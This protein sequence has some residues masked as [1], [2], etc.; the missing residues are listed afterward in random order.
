MSIYN[1]AQIPRTTTYRPPNDI[2]EQKHNPPPLQ[3]ELH[4][5]INNHR[6]IQNLLAKLDEEATTYRL[7]LLRTLAA[8]S[9]DA[10]D[11]SFLAVVARLKELGEERRRH[12]NHLQKIESI[13]QRCMLEFC[14]DFS[15]IMV[16]NDEKLEGHWFTLTKPT[17]TDCLG[18][19]DDGDPLYKLGRMSFEMFFP[20]DLVCAIQAVFNSIITVNSQSLQDQSSFSI[21]KTLQD[22]VK[23]AL[24]TDSLRTYE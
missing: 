5:L 6:S 9:G 3:Q 19:N 2:N 24:A 23:L 16:N 4:V 12:V 21:P 13:L 11:V 8:A 20:G 15:T 17:Y 7:K 1:D 10:N 18:F 14:D 22:E